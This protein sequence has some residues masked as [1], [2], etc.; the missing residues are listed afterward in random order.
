MRREKPLLGMVFKSPGSGNKTHTM[1]LYEILQMP[2]ANAREARNFRA[3]EDFVARLD[4]DHDSSRCNLLSP[5][6]FH[7]SDDEVGALRMGVNRARSVRSKS[8]RLA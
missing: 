8:L 6:R 5:L 1:A 7:D 4:G 3:R 2:G